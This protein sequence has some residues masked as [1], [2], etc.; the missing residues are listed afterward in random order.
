MSPT[1]LGQIWPDNRGIVAMRPDGSQYLLGLI[2]KK[3]IRK[4]QAQVSFKW[5]VARSEWISFSGSCC[6][7]VG[8]VL[9]ESVRAVPAAGFAAVAALEEKLRSED[10][11]AVFQVVVFAF[12]QLRGITHIWLEN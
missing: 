2:S 3:R 5:E 7:V 1:L 8:R 12:N 11:V 6:P 4:S 9:F 10:V